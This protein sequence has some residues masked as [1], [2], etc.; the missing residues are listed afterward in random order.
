MI[1]G[2]YVDKENR[3]ELPVLAGARKRR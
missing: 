3:K 2:G 1:D